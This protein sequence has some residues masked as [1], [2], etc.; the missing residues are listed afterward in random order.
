MA[1][2]L[3]FFFRGS[4]ALCGGFF[5]PRPLFP[6]RGRASTRSLF[7]QGKIVL[8]GTAHTIN[9]IPWLGN[10]LRVDGD[11]K[12]HHVRVAHAGEIDADTLG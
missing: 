8:Q 6:G 4:L 3:T 1:D 10:Q 11:T 9:D 2:P 12:P 7:C 5:L